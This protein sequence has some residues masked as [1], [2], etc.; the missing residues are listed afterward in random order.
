MTERNL[1]SLFSALY[2]AVYSSERYV[3][4]IRSFPILL[5]SVKRKRH[6]YRKSWFT[7]NYA[8]VCKR[9][10]VCIFASRK[11]FIAK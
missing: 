7:V 11:I 6:G 2:Q 10:D 9:G 8:R 4:K 5:N 1:F 3:T